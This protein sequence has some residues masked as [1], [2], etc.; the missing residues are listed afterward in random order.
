MDGT[1][2]ADRSLDVRISLSGDDPEDQLADLLEWINDDATLRD[3]TRPLIDE[4]QPG[5]LSGG[6][7]QALESAVASKE[8]LVALI[9][10][11]AGWLTARVT[12]RRVKI[13]VKRGDSEVS[14]EADAKQLVRADDVVDSILHR[15]DA[16]DE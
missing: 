15:L 13:Q 3:Q 6:T 12:G 8:L 10:S 2:D 7:L 11:A 4:P 5:E 14:L 9:S 1:P 16:R